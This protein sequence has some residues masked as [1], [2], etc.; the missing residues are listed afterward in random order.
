MVQA[1]V[2]PPINMKKFETLSYLPPLTTEQLAKEVDYLLRSGWVPCLEF[3]LEVSTFFLHIFHVLCYMFLDIA[4]DNCVLN[5]NVA[6]F[7]VPWAQQIPR[8]LWR[9][10]L[11]YVEASH[12]RVHRL[13]AGVEGA[14]WVRQG[15]PPGVRP[16][17]RIR[18]R[19]PSPVHQ[20]HCSPARML[21]NLSVDFIYLSILFGSYI[22][23]LQFH[24]IPFSFKF[25]TCISN[26]RKFEL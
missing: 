21:I 12:V 10:I 20:F 14:W 22:N 23:F 17:H 5:Q 11:G 9:T 6:R 26:T 24:F 1:Q 18:Q 15:V 19:S 16:Y 7:R 8:I 4:D 3:E 25:L 13:I 2:W